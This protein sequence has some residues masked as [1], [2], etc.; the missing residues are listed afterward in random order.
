VAFD[1]FGLGEDG[2]GWGGEFLV[3]D[4]AT[5]DRAAHLRTVPQPG[6]DAA[7]RNPVRM[8]LAHAADA[9]VLPKALRLLDMQPSRARVVLQQI[10]SGLNSPLTSSAGRLFDAVA[11]LTG[12]CR[13]STYEG[14]PAI[15]LEQAADTSATFEYP[16]DL[17]EDG[18][19][20][21][22][23]TRPIVKAVVVDLAKG[24]SPG[25]VA[26]RFHRTVAAG[27]LSVCR[28]VRG[29]SGLTRVC[30]AGGVF[31]ND[32]LTSD[33]VARLQSCDFEVFVPREVPVGDGGIAL[34]QV[35]VAHGRTSGIGG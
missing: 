21:V 31:Q 11:A 32:L 4:W 12:V 10:E 15:L 1:G 3:C 30:L 22:L 5:A 33:V 13:R 25:E 14:H 17:E 26:G 7:V 28:L 20:L 2:T 24:R 16:F 9:G 27:I 8:A 34:G 18:G 29:R 35:L 23:D 6:G 19:S